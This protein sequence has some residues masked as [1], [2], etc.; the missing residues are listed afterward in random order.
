MSRIQLLITHYFLV[1]SLTEILDLVKA[2]YLSYGYLIVLVATYIEYVVLLGYIWPGG[3]VILI[4]LI[5]SVNG[6]LSWL[7]I[8]G[9]FWVGAVLGN[10]TNYWLGRKGAL[11][12]LKASRFYPKFEP[13]LIRAS[14]F[15]T[16]YG[17]RSVFISQLVGYI[18]PFVALLAGAAG[19][20]LRQFMLF[21]LPAV[22]LWD[23][24]FCGLGY[25]LARSFSNVE[26][27][28]SGI[29]LVILVL[30][31]LTWLGYRFF[32]RRRLLSKPPSDSDSSPDL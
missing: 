32:M 23:I 15:L 17:R 18:R 9:A 27:I 4:G 1:Y 8:V 12:L 10:L 24:I 31:G 2:Q 21:Q 7:L 25:L 13:Y 28:L 6:Q 11:G 26:S 5:Y 19:M 30:V 16:K 14:E 20:P 29:G 22:L 3:T